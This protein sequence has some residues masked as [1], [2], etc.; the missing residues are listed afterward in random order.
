MA[1]SG[2]ERPKVSV[3]RCCDP[4]EPE[5]GRTLRSIT[6][7]APLTLL[8]CLLF[9]ATS[10]T[11]SET[12]SER[13]VRFYQLQ[14]AS[15]LGLQQDLQLCGASDNKSLRF[16]CESRSKPLSGS[17]L[18]LFL[19]HSPNLDG[20][21]SFLSVS[22][23][24]GILRSL[25]LDGQNEKRAEVIIPLPPE[26]LTMENEL[27]FS[28]TQFP[29]QPASSSVCTSIKVDSHIEIARAEGA[30][31][32]DLS[33]FPSPL[34]DTHSY[35]PQ[36]IALLVPETS[37]SETLEATALLAASLAKQA[38]ALP[39]QFTLL[40]T[41]QSAA[42][43]LLIIGTPQE[44]PQ[45][46]ELQGKTH[47]VVSE[48]AATRA[49]GFSEADMLNESE[50][51]V[52]ITTGRE[53]SHIPILFVTANS[54]RGVL[55]ATRHLLGGTA[56]LTG[57]LIRI[58]QPAVPPRKARRHWAGFIPPPSRFRLSDLKA[59]EVRIGS[60]KDHSG[61]L[62][63]DAPPDVR[64]LDYGHQ[65]NLALKLNPGQIL[66]PRLAVYLNNALIGRFASQ[67]MF[68]GSL[69]A[70]RIDV[71]ARLLAVRNTLKLGWEGDGDTDNFPVAAT[72]L[73]NSEFYL[74]RDYRAQLPDLGLLQSNL[75]PFSLQ[76]G[77]EDLVVVI[78]DPV[79]VDTVALLTELACA[80]GRLAPSENLGFRVRRATEFSRSDRAGSNVILLNPEIGGG[81]TQRLFGHWKPLPWIEVLKGFPRVQQQVSPWNSS[82]W[83]LLFE[84]KSLPA[85]QE[86]VRLCFSESMLKQLRED[87]AVLTPARPIPFSISAK[88][89]VRE[90]LYLMHLEAWMRTHWV[91]LPI[92]L[93][94][95]SVVLLVGLRVVLGNYK[96]A[97][98]AGSSIGSVS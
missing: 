70:V 38:G 14:F 85:L 79:S 32:V 7:K 21:R 2:L 24:Y 60:M 83:V 33:L 50:G 96:R 52:G 80:L 16:H 56:R 89:T 59:P 8:A 28:A 74:P 3:G 67:E 15:Q 9:C 75:Y 29:L 35:R 36:K 6:H 17:R 47:L 27:V 65:M 1:C 45:L 68:S 4:S 86:A 18:R 78:P 66:P 12:R 43:P 26:L 97:R 72:L 49:V 42:D 39:L 19:E 63:L 88:Q 10:L 94:L 20:E 37:T 62:R 77:L 57:T 84:A 30:S 13:V 95:A 41:I 5:R 98:N 51:I 54:S 58:S 23:N 46:S 44:Q 73:P 82:K 90:Y 55:N 34:V 48:T 92:V 31:V 64:F 76:P 87:A 69:A 81:L 91:A 53:A 25:R 22:L 40:R 71:P 93:T 61:L 11:Q